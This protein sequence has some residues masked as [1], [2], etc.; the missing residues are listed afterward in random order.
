LNIRRVRFERS[1]KKKKVDMSNSTRLNESYGA[2]DAKWRPLSSEGQEMFQFAERSRGLGLLDG[3]PAMD[4]MESLSVKVACKGSAGSGKTCTALRLSGH[5]P[6]P[7]Y[8]ATRG[9]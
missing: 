3:T 7:Q 8:M 6:E 9:T 2:V 4:G 5:S 1:D